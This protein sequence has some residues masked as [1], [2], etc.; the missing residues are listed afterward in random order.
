MLEGDNRFGKKNERVFICDS[1]HNMVWHSSETQ[2]TQYTRYQCEFAGSWNDSSWID[3]PGTLQ[4]RAWELQLIDATW[5]CHQVCKAEMTGV[6]PDRRM[7]RPQKWRDEAKWRE[8]ERSS[9][10]RHW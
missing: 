10:R 5:T 6:N 8:E 7:A 3:I 4:H 9:R 2:G 1:C